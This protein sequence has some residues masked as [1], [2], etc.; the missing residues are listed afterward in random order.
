MHL[1]IIGHITSDE[2]NRLLTSTEAANGF[3]NRFLWIYTE[4]SKA[5]SRGGN[6]NDD[7]LRPFVERIRRIRDRA[8]TIGRIDFGTEAGKL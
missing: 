7:D 2:L 1:G 6:L 4:R 8:Q 3:A 5:L